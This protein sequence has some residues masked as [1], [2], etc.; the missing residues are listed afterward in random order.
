MEAAIRIERHKGL[1]AASR[2]L[3]RVLLFCSPADAYRNMP[4]SKVAH[5]YTKFA[6]EDYD[7]L[8]KFGPNYDAEIP[9]AKLCIGIKG[10]RD[11]ILTVFAEQPVQKIANVNYSLISTSYLFNPECTLENKLLPDLDVIE[12]KGKQKVTDAANEIKKFYEKEGWEVAFH[13]DKVRKI[14]VQEK[15]QT[16][17]SYNK[18]RFPRKITMLDYAELIRLAEEKVDY[19]LL[20]LCFH[21]RIYR[22]GYVPKN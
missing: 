12:L 19:T 2:E 1:H 14:D 22:E 4:E 15:D 21:K 8:I 20:G 18:E 6:V 9:D 10:D 17:L 7:K 5:A 16:C 11:W 13:Y 3:H